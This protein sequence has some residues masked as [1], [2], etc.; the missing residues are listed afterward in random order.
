MSVEGNKTT[1]LLEAVVHR[2]PASCDIFLALIHASLISR[3]FSVAGSL[4]D[5]ECKLWKSLELKEQ[6]VRKWVEFWEEQGNGLNTKEFYAGV[7]AELAE[8]ER[9]EKKMGCAV[10]EIVSNH[11]YA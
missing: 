3:S 7:Q 11:C 2:Q 4:L 5:Q 10:I 8:A 9:G 1:P 6:S